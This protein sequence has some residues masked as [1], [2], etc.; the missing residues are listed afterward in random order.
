MPEEYIETKAAGTITPKKGVNPRHLHN[1][2]QDA[3][4]A[5]NNLEK[6]FQATARF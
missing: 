5:L 4:N 3:I 2:Q 1:H 6:N